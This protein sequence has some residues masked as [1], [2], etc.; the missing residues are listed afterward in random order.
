MGPETKILA[1]TQD[2]VDDVIQNE[3]TFSNY[4]SFGPQGFELN[5]IKYDDQK[6]IVLGEDTITNSE[7]PGD[8]T[9]NITLEPQFIKVN[10]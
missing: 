6:P 4:F 3:K 2:R 5:E 1:L 10:V 7:V 9:F 8:L